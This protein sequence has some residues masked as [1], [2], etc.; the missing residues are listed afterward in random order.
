MREYV[1]AGVRLVWYIDPASRTVTV[2]LNETDSVELEEDQILTG[3]E[4]LPGFEV[5]VRQLSTNEL[6][7]DLF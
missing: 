1:Q 2:Y 6:A 4:V 5:S 3:G 7:L